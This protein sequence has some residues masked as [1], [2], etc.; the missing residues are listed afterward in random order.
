MTETATLPDASVMQG[1]IPYIGYGGRANEAEDFY[2]KAFGASDLGRMPNPEAPE[3]LMHAQ[4]EING[5][6][7]MMTD[8]GCEP[9]PIRAL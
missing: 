3:S 9:V 1:V 7:L 8:H 4:I 6:A 5:G 2:A